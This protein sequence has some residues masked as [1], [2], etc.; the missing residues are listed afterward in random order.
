[1]M[2]QS[3]SCLDEAVPSLPAARSYHGA[4]MRM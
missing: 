3:W 2:L 1:M 4:H